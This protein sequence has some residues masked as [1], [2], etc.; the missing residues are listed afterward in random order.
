MRKHPP[1]L[2]AP[3]VTTLLR[4]LGRSG[5]VLRVNRYYRTGAGKHVV[6]D[7]C[8]ADGTPLRTSTGEVRAIDTAVSPMRAEDPIGT[9]YPIGTAVA[10]TR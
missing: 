4:E 1:G 8:D 7:L 5:A 9:P 3:E 10:Q 2:I 6:Y